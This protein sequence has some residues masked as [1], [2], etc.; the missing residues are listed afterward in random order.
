M[1]LWPIFKNNLSSTFPLEPYLRSSRARL[2]IA[3]IHHSLD[4]HFRHSRASPRQIG[5][6]GFGVF[7]VVIRDGGFDGVFRKHGAMYYVCHIPQSVFSHESGDTHKSDRNAPLLGV[8]ESV[9]IRTLDRR[10]TQLSGN[11]RIPDFARI[12]KRHSSHE[13]RQIRTTRNCASA[14]KCLELHVGDGV[15][16]GVDFDLQFHDVATGWSTDEPCTDVE[17]G[18]V[19]GADIARRGIVV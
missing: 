6:G 17:R 19:H 16:C 15:A 12:L 7:R 10:Q 14:S 13:F 11:L 3:T 18:L 2:R 5:L 4:I 1:R 8:E 9:N